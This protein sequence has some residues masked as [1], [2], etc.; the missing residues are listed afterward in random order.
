MIDLSQLLTQEQTALENRELLAELVKLSISDLA[1]L[2][3]INAEK[4]SEINSE[5]ESKVLCDSI[6]DIDK[7]EIKKFLNKSQKLSLLI[8]EANNLKYNNY[9]NK[10]E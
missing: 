3:K 7:I 9:L 2:E 5:I 6:D 4:Q 8:R 1:E 10:I